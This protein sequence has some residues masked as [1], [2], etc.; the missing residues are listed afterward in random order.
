MN[1]EQP[2]EPLRQYAVVRILDI[3][4]H[5]DKPFTYYLT[6]ELAG[7]AAVGCFVLVPFGVS[8]RRVM[9]LVTDLQ[10]PKDLP[11]DF[12]VDRCKPVSRVVSAEFV[13]NEE[14]LGLCRYMKEMTFCSLGDAARAVIP[15]G[16]LRRIHE[17]YILP[18]DPESMQN[19]EAY[20]ASLAGA[21]SL[22]GDILALV[23][24]KKGVRREKL[25]E[26]FGDGAI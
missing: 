23:K 22:E 18:E 16:A 24:K 12:P 25:T 26:S 7:T 3:P 19:A 13:L 21:S 14:L 6:P 17:R 5:V 8:N 2:G 1:T 11:A 10:S 4:Y 20:L 9:G 15:T